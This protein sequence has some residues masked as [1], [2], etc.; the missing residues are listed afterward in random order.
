MVLPDLLRSAI[1]LLTATAIA[2]M[3][4]RSIWSKRG[5]LRFVY[6]V[7]LALVFGATLLLPFDHDAEYGTIRF[8]FC[9]LA[10]GYAAIGKAN[11]EIGPVDVL[12]EIITVVHTIAC[13]QISKFITHRGILLALRFLDSR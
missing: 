9:Y 2:W 13:I 11:F 4:G 1:A 6:G 10:L 5:G 3:L 8:W 12:V 7:V